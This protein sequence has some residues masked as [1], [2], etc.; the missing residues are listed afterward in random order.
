MFNVAFKFGVLGL[1]SWMTYLLT[2]IATQV[3]NEAPTIII[4]IGITAGGLGLVCFY[5]AFVALIL[6]TVK[7]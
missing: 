5:G 6:G 4:A 2:V 1:L 3:K 7:K